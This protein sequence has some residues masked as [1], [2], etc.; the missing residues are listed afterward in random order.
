MDNHYNGLKGQ[1]IRQY[2]F[3]R[4]LGQGA[5]AAVYEVYDQQYK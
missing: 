5:W 4:K 3:I 1:R 2:N